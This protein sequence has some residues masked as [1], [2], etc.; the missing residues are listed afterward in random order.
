M[1]IPATRPRGHGTIATSINRTWWMLGKYERALAETL[2]D[3]GYMQG[4]ALAS[5]GREREAIAA[6]RWRERETGFQF[7]ARHIRPSLIH[8]SR[9]GPDIRMTRVPSR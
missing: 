9:T 6:L 8:A 1:R 5:L 4:L 7:S 2:G 3:I